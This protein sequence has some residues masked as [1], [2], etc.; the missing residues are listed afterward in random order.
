MALAAVG[1]DSQ[2]KPL[3]FVAMPFADEYADRFHYGIQGAVNAAGF[4]CERADLAS[5][6]GDVIAW[7]K[8]RID[9]ASLVVADL[10][11]ANPNV[12]LEVGYAWGRGVNT[13]LL[14]AHGDELKF[15]VRTQRCLVFRSIRHL[16][17]LLT[18]E[19]NSLK[20][21]VSRSTKTDT[22]IQSAAE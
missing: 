13:I 7:V 18:G 12:Y 10:T 20:G 9:N 11:T 21:R 16:E 2:S 3:V 19:L 17:Q 5:F 14:V 22:A 15:D 6:T 1:R 4:L 8:Q